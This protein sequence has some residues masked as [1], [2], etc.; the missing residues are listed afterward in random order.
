MSSDPESDLV[1]VHKWSVDVSPHYRSV[2]SGAV[3]VSQVVQ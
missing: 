3:K 1:E 2:T